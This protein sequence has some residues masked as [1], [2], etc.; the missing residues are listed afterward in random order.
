MLDFIMGLSGLLLR[1]IMPW[2]YL[3]GT[4]AFIVYVF[5]TDEDRE[6]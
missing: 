5:R 4:V 1:L 3:W 2:F 6:S